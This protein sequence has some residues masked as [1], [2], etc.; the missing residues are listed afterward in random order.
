MRV[1]CAG[2][3]P[4][5]SAEI[6]FAGG[7]EVAA[8]GN[9]QLATGKPSASISI[10]GTKSTF[11]LVLLVLFRAYVLI[12]QASFLFLPLLCTHRTFGSGT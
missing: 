1:H 6:W 8:A 5:L 12:L 2:V 9:R 10:S 3:R 7:L 4:L 11:A